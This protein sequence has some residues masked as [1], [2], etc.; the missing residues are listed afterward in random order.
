MLASRTGRPIVPLTF[1]ASK[2][3]IFNSWDRFLFPY[4]FSRGVFIWGDPIWV[5]P[6]E[7][8][9]VVEENRKTLESRLNHITTQAD[10]YFDR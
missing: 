1:G 5:D 2:K 6:G 9:A 3:K 10:H 4:P 7:G 8:Q